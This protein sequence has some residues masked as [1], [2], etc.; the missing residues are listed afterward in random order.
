MT[1]KFRN[2]YTSFKLCEMLY[3]QH[4]IYTRETNAEKLFD[5]F[6]HYCKLFHVVKEVN[7]ITARTVLPR[8]LEDDNTICAIN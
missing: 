1:S 7:F 5:S 4:P 6:V 8:P 3:L 2:R